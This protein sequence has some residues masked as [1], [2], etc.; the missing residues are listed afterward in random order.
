MLTDFVFADDRDA[1]KELE[2]TSK[3]DAMQKYIDLCTSLKAD[4]DNN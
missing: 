3:E 1:W 4:W 2:G